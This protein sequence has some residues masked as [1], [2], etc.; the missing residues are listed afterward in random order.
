M[1]GEVNA[2]SRKVKILKCFFKKKKSRNR[3]F[4]STRTSLEM[5]ALFFPVKQARK[6]FFRLQ[7]FVYL[8]KNKKFKLKE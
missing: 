8:K 3:Y 2:L 7:I 4:G 5:F 1:E 6:Y